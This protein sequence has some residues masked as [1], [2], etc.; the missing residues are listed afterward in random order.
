MKQTTL[1]ATALVASTS[2][3]I[4]CASC[5]EA[6]NAES[7]KAA[8]DSIVFQ[9]D[10]TG[11]WTEQ[12]FLDGNEN[13]TVENRE[14]G[15]YF[16]GGTVTKPMDREA[17]HAHHAVLWTKQVF[18]GDLRISFEMTRL[19][20]SDYGNTLLYI[21]AE[22]VGYGPFAEDITEWQEMRNVSAMSKYFN[23]MNLLSLSFRNNLRARRY[24]LRDH[25]D[26]NQEAQGGTVRPHV[27]Y[28]GMVPG[29]T[30]LVDVQKEGPNLTLRLADK[31]TGE[32]YA[33]H[34]WDMTQVGGEKA[35]EI[36]EKGRIGLRHMSTKQ[37]LYKN[38]KVEQL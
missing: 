28:I 7:Q 35:A 8:E 4:G 18:E 2:L 22:G 29:K 9:D 34:T 12:W 26:P 23:N 32:S 3:T 33:D 25:P 17:Y 36:I 31:A 19:D 5:D 10:M 11:D 20:E 27:D 24:P 16:S 30:Y 14:D 37:F 15:L 1:I 21:L 38:F 6:Y 13:A